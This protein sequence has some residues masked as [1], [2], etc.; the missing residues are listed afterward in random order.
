[1]VLT[2]LMFVLTAQSAPVFPIA[3]RYAAED[4][5]Q[6]ER[7]LIAIRALG[8]TAVVVADDRAASIRGAASAAELQIIPKRDEEKPPMVLLDASGAPAALR[9]RG[10]TAM[11]HGARAIAFAME[12][13]FAATPDS[14]GLIAPHLR[15]AGDFGSSVA[16]SSALFLTIKPI[17]GARSPQVDVRLFQSRQALVLIAL[18]H[19]DEAVDATI[20][21]PSGMPLAEWVDLETGEIAYFDR[22]SDGVAHRHRFAARDALVLVIRKDIQ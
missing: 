20:V 11:R 22:V 3:V 7:D 4:G 21:L 18:N 10:W 2:L 5:V 17:E 8:F 6:W 9:Y 15:V 1:V 12:A 13:R 14:T 16:G 19:R